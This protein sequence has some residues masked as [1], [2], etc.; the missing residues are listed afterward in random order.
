MASPVGHFLGLAGLVGTLLKK[1][2]KIKITSQGAYFRKYSE[3]SGLAASSALRRANRLPSSGAPSWPKA[4][5]RSG[6]SS[7][8]R[9]PKGMEITKNGRQI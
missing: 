8:I 9:S 7:A 6:F 4:D 5:A 1:G 3:S 2:N